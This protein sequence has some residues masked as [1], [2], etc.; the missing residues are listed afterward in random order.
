LAV[1]VKEKIVE[2]NNQA[3]GKDKEKKQDYLFY[4][5]SSSISLKAAGNTARSKEESR[6]KLSVRVISVTDTRK[7]TG[8]SGKDIFSAFIGRRRAYSR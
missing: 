2:K 6:G 3:E 7:K 4:Y 8:F 1:A 5:L